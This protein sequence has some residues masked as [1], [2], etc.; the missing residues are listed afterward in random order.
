M[1][2]SLPGYMMNVL[3]LPGLAVKEREV[4]SCS[5]CTTSYG[6][7][8]SAV[9]LTIKARLGLLGCRGASETPRRGRGCIRGS[10]VF[11]VL[12]VFGWGVGNSGVFLGFA[13][14]RATSWK[15][16]SSEG[17]SVFSGG[18]SDCSASWGVE[19]SSRAAA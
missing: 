7:G 16:S 2:W 1:V 18:E 6:L 10:S 9:G 19:G 5:I 8:K 11:S 14:L 3:F 15:G 17:V 12:V 4:S 13:F